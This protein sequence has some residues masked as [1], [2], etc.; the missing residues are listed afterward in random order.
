MST[1][2]VVH[3]CASTSGR[4]E[5][6][7]VPRLAPSTSSTRSIP[8]GSRASVR[9]RIPRSHPA[10]PGSRVSVSMTRCPAP[11]NGAGTQNPASATGRA[12]PIFKNSG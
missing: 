5:A 7:T 6:N 11:M 3:A 9:S 2:G 10:T 12:S 1:A 8:S 4:N